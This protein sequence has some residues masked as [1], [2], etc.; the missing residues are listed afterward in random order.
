MPQ[1][2][3]SED[4]KMHRPSSSALLLPLHN[5]ILLSYNCKVEHLKDK[6]AR[7]T[8]V[9]ILYF[10][11]SL[12]NARLFPNVSENVE[13]PLEATSMEYWSRREKVIDDG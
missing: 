11:S 5:D 12:W 3:I 7:S 13:I 9:H 10:F 6:E 2:S 8:S 1:K 4:A